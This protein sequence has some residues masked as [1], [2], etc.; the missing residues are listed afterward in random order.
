MTP[1]NAVRCLRLLTELESELATRIHRSFAWR[2]EE[3]WKAMKDVH[4]SVSS[5]FHMARQAIFIQV[6]LGPLGPDIEFTV[7]RGL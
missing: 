3:T 6:P 2:D 4:H 7:H 5:Y 1:E